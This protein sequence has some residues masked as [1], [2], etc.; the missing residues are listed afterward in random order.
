M[1]NAMEFHE[2]KAPQFVERLR[3]NGLI[4]RPSG[5]NIVKF[6]PALIMTESIVDESMEIFRKSLAET[7]D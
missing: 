3:A 6:T 2:G 4:V 7:F 1:L 5:A